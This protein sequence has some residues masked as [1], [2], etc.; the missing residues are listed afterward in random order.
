ME[1]RKAI[2][3]MKNRSDEMGP[4][5]EARVLVCRALQPALYA[6]ID[7]LRECDDMVMTE[8]DELA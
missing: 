8:D 7:H 6:A 2:L 3:P 4:T 1:G 5:A